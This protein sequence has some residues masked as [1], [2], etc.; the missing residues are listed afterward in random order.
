[1]RNST[2]F[3]I[4]LQ[5]CLKEKAF[6]YLMFYSSVHLYNIEKKY[7]FWN[8]STCLN[9][10]CQCKISFKKYIWYLSCIVF[11][12]ARLSL[13]I[14]SCNPF[15]NHFYWNNFFHTF[16]TNSLYLT[17]QYSCIIRAVLE[18]E[19]EAGLRFKKIIFIFVWNL[20]CLIFP[21]V[22]INNHWIM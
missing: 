9:F 20:M 17:M 2:V 4:R 8:F 15:L 16:H 10:Y 6:S 18:Q 7:M 12:Y 1:M 14:Q 11:Y 19:V 3:A 22:S 13:W 21:N 5:M